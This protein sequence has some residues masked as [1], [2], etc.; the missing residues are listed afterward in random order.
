[1]AA[2]GWMA[3]RNDR[4]PNE[5]SQ[6]YGCVRCLGHGGGLSG[7]HMC[8]SSCTHTRYICCASAIPSK[9]GFENYVEIMEGPSE[10]LIWV[11]AFEDV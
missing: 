9:A 1:M 4:G 10:K 2:R 11:H 3:G 8:H 5:S 7:I 6:D